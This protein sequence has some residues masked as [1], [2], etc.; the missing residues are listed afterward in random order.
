MFVRRCLLPL[1]TILA[2]LVPAPSP[3]AG[4]QDIP[5]GPG[6]VVRI[7][8]ANRPELSGSFTVRPDGLLSLPALGE[9]SAA[10]AT[11]GVLSVRLAAA[12]GERLGANAPGMAVE[13]ERF[14]PVY[15]GGDVARPGEHAFRPM[16]RAA[17]LVALAGGPRAP[18]SGETAIVALEISRER[19]KLHRQRDELAV[20]LARRG[21][22]R[23]ELEATAAADVPDAAA[24]QPLVGIERARGLAAD[25]AQ[26]LADRAELR[27]LLLVTLDQRRQVNAEEVVA[28]E[29]QEAAL[30]QQ[31][32]LIRAELARLES[33]G[34][35][36]FFPANRL[37]QLRQDLANVEGRRSEAQALRAR[38]RNEGLLI[39]SSIETFDRSRR[40]ELA[41]ELAET[42]AL[43]T[44]LR[45]ALA[46]TERVLPQLDGETPGTPS[47]PRRMALQVWRSGP[48]GTQCLEA[49][50]ATPLRP[51]DLLR[52]GRDA[53]RGC[54]ADLAGAAR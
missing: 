31:A 8:F 1:L 39:A 11:I 35:A 33:G 5:L 12:V 42:D 18:T 19:E 21:R 10:G 13:V 29:A 16:M 28:V 41:T 32:Q 15:V 46:E 44:R 53:A 47:Q 38:A 6:D 52:V 50:D 40:I 24:L 3:A 22:L 25:E 45:A 17:H 48:A 30:A 37:L 34:Q 14:G 4:E 43:V 51:G 49:D 26:R 36:N 27:R 2:L 9:I 20:A 23:R 7:V 54:Q